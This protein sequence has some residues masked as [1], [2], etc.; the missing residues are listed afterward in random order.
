MV[1]FERVN[2]KQTLALLK[3]CWLLQV[4]YEWWDR[5]LLTRMLTIQRMITLHQITSQLKVGVSA[6]WYTLH[7]IDFFLHRATRI[8]SLA[9]KALI[10]DWNIDAV[11]PGQARR[12]SK[13]VVFIYIVQF[14]WEVFQMLQIQ[15][16]RRVLCKVIWLCKSYCVLLEF[17][18]VYCIYFIIGHYPLFNL[19]LFSN[20]HALFQQHS[21]SSLCMAG[22]EVVPGTLS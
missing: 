5:R 19:T 14:N 3:N 13:F 9:P 11:P 22:M 4:W 10:V 6:K 7:C 21:A 17:T 1:N 15:S 2:F 12:V 20:G 18:G 16:V 8:P